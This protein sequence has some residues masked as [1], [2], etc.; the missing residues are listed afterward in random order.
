MSLQILPSPLL[1]KHRLE[2]CLSS[3]LLPCPIHIFPCSIYQY[4]SLCLFPCPS[5]MPHPQMP[6]PPSSKSI[7]AACLDPQF[8]SSPATQSA[9]PIPEP[10]PQPASS[11]ATQSIIQ[12]SPPNTVFFRDVLYVFSFIIYISYM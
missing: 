5:L 2:S 10:A 4:L 6:A 3:I 11:P 7:S 9:A 12:P 1:C 8:T